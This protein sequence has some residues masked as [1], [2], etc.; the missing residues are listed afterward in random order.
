M[1][2]IPIS[3]SMSKNGYVYTHSAIETS[4]AAGTKTKHIQDTETLEDL[5]F[6]LDPMFQFRRSPGFPRF[7]SAGIASACYLYISSSSV[8]QKNFTT[9]RL[10]YVYIRETHLQA[11]VHYTTR[12]HLPCLMQ[13]PDAGNTTVWSTSHF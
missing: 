13:A 1:K 8:F 9:T 3:L 6:Y 10:R 2:R 5:S 12:S 7:S 4:I 11:D